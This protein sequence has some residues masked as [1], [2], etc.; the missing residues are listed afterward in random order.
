M[1][2]TFTKKE[3]AA[4]MNLISKVQIIQSPHDCFHL[5]FIGSFESIMDKWD[6]KKFKLKPDYKLTMTLKNAQVGALWFFAMECQRQGLPDEFE[7]AILN[8]IIAQIEPYSL[9]INK[10]A[11]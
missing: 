7:D 11:N 6:K 4:L 9:N 1:K 2:I 3:L 8:D 10:N 5:M